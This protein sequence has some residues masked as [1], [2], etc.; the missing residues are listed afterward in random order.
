MITFSYKS[1]IMLLIIIVLFSNNIKSCDSSNSETDG[2]GE[3][4][5]ENNICITDE[6]FQQKYGNGI[7]GNID[8]NSNPNI[9]EE[10]DHPEEKIR[11]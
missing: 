5:C 4:I 8:N 2:C 7:F 10:D 1:L 3:D 9:E 11:V 6:I